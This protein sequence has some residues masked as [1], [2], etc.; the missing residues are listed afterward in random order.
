VFVELIHF[1]PNQNI[2]RKTFSRSLFQKEVFEIR[3]CSFVSELNLRST[4]SADKNFADEITWIT[5]KT[6][7]NLEICP[8][9]NSHLEV[10]FLKESRWLYDG[11]NRIGCRD[12]LSFLLTPMVT[13]Y[14]QV[15][16]DRT[17][18]SEI[19]GAWVKDVT[20]RSVARFRNPWPNK[21]PKDRRGTGVTQKKNLFK[22]NSS[23]EIQ[24]R[25][26]L[27]SHGS[28]VLNLSKINES[29]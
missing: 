8:F 7:Q 23:K 15:M 16:R 13:D 20:C 6:D 2:C 19:F 29:W 25:L 26:R 17:T 12:S 21:V 28:S 3:G 14:K 11:L 22:T 1:S 9:L 5:W 27:T 10:D 4:F 24:T 18:E